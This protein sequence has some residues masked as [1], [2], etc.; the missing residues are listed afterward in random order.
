VA[1]VTRRLGARLAATVAI[2]AVLTASLALCPCAEPPRSADVH[3]CCAAE[4]GFRA[5]PDDCC[6]EPGDAPLVAS[7]PSVPPGA[8]PSTYAG[9][10]LP[11]PAV[12]V[13]V[14]VPDVVSAVPSPPFN[15]R[16]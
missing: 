9:A 2:M 4:P 15:L 10:A 14:A 16:I 11:V 13:A 3:D 6:S 7:V 8:V 12:R 5:A 1:S